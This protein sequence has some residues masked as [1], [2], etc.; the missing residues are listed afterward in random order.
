MGDRARQ[1]I[2][3]NYT[4]DI[5]AKK[6]IQVYSDILNTKATSEEYTQTI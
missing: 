4:W 5:A 2:L 1:F 6:L 3:Q